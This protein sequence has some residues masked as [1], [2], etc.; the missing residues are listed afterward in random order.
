MQAIVPH[1]KGDRPASRAN[2]LQLALPT[3]DKRKLRV[4]EAA[5]HA[6]PAI[7]WSGVGGCGRNYRGRARSGAI[8]RIDF[9]SNS[10]R[11]LHSRCALLAEIGWDISRR[12]S[13][14][15]PAAQIRD[16][17]HGRPATRG[18]TWRAVARRHSSWMRDHRAEDRAE[19]IRNIPAQ[20]EIN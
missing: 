19:R 17:E 18:Q 12:R 8:Y 5:Q 16:N 20:A 14:F 9:G 4:N 15:F 7:C 13:W 3:R 1:T 10:S 11:N 2:I 6:A